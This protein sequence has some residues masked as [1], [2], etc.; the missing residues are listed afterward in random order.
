MFWPSTPWI[1]ALA[2]APCGFLLLSCTSL[3]PVPAHSSA[4]Q[5]GVT[6]RVE[7]GKCQGWREGARVGIV[8]GFWKSVA[9]A[10]G[11]SESGAEAVCFC[12]ASRWEV[13]APGEYMGHRHL[14]DH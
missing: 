12:A 1:E 14:H 3:P 9:I 5:L 4:F 7:T 11:Q 6:S 2:S 13:L 10:P 8:I